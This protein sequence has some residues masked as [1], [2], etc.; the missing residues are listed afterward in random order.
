MALVPVNLKASIINDN[1]EDND[2]DDSTPALSMNRVFE[3]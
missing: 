2:D 3:K 1:E